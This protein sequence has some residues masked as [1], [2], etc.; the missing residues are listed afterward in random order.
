[1]YRVPSY[2]LM[3]RDF[4]RKIPLDK[5]SISDYTLFTF[6]TMQ[7]SLLYSINITQDQLQVHD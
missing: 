4:H 6:C 2:H 5:Q 7:Y 3:D 1:M